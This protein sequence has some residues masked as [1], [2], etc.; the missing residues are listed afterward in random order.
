[1]LSTFDILGAVLAAATMGQA[2]LTASLLVVRKDPRGIYLPLFI[3]FI[4]NAVA[5]LSGIAEI[6]ATT[7]QTLPFRHFVDLGS[8]VAFTLISPSIWLYVRALTS[9]QPLRFSIRDSWHLLAFGIGII[10]S[11][12]LLS[13]PFEVRHEVIGDGEVS[14]SGQ[15]VFLTLA[16]LTLMLTWIIQTAIYVVK[17]FVRLTRYRMR[18]KDVFASTE[19]RELHWISWVVTLLVINFLIVITDMFFSVSPAVSVISD[20]FDFAMVW[21]LSVWGL[22]VTP[23]IDGSG[24][25]RR[26]AASVSEREDTAITKRSAAKYEKSALTAEH[27]ARI[28][29]KLN[30]VMLDKKLYLEPSLSLRDLAK[31]ISTPPNYVSQTLNSQIG[32]TFFDYVNGW[33]IRDAMPRISGSHEPILSILYDVG[34]NSRS[35]FYKAFKRETGMTPRAYRDTHAEE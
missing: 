23:S 29:E 27:L 12:L 25:P 32:E 22:R 20:T 26:E 9:E 2:C 33:R 28:S 19:G 34:F 35:S 11:V 21:I 30:R 14:D 31:A 13:S 15:I 7:R 24:G 1:M 4:A 8:I 17:I 3:F 16:V 6:L 5:E 18:L 10:V